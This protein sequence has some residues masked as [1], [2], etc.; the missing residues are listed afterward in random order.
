MG[1]AF[2]GIH[3]RFRCI[4]WSMIGHSGGSR[5][6][7]P[8]CWH[9]CTDCSCSSRKCGIHLSKNKHHL[10]VPIQVQYRVWILN[11]RPSLRERDS[12]GHIIVGSVHFWYCTV[13]LSY[14][15]FAH[16]RESRYN[17]HYIM[18]SLL[19]CHYWTRR[20]YTRAGLG[21]SL[22]LLAYVLL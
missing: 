22:P 6:S 5:S 21:D 3:S 1:M 2:Y 18:M 11:N 16:S 19:S 15:S 7:R 12:Q 13:V 8:L 10:W 20:R 14:P 4:G 17:Q 9:V